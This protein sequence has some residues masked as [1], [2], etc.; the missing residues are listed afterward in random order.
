VV[1]KARVGRFPAIV[2]SFPESK[3]THFQGKTFLMPEGFHLLNLLGYAGAIL[4]YGRFYLQWIVSERKGRSVVPV[5]FWYMS[6]AGSL[7]LLLYGVFYLNSPVG[8]MSHCFNSI[9]YARN[10]VHIWRADGKLSDRHSRLFH[11]AVA[12]LVTAGSFL[13]LLTLLRE[14]QATRDHAFQDQ[15]RNWMWI[16]VGVLGQGLFALRFLVQW[17]VTEIKQQST[18]PPV[19]W[20][21]SVAASLLLIS[22]HAQRQEWLY[23]VGISTTLFVYLRNIYWVRHGA[24]A[25]AQE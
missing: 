3:N 17:I 13:V 8:A 1:G 5:A 12:C 20:Y 19:F 11:G 25:S 22:S 6:G 24:G 10:L 2:L 4:F 23:A 7:L 14:F 16:G 15:A 21:L 18:I 9:I